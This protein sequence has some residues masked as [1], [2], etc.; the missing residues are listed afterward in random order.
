MISIDQNCHSLWD[1][2]PK[3]Q[4]LVGRGMPVRHF[5]EDIDVAFTEVGASA[6]SDNGLARPGSLRLERERYYRGREADWGA[7]LFYHQ[8]LGRQAVDIREW[9]PLTGLSTKALSGRLGRG[10]AELYEEFSPSDNWQLIGP[11]YAGQGGHHRVIGDLSVAET[12]GFLREVLRKAREDCLSAMPE[13]PCR[14]RLEEWFTREAA[15]LESLLA[16]HAAG[17]LV[18]LYKDWMASYLGA[19]V[20]LDLSSRLFGLDGDPTRFE[21]LEVF[22]RDYDVASGLYNE[23]IAETGSFLRPLEVQGGELPFFAIFPH[24]GRLVRTATFLDGESL[25]V[26]ARTFPLAPGRRLPVGA[27]AKAGIRATGGKAILLTIQARLGEV[28]APLALPYRGSVY[29]PASHRLARKLRDA[30]LL[31]GRLHPIVRVRL[32]LLDRLAD[33]NVSIRVPE[34]LAR[35]FGKDVVPAREIGLNHARLAEEAQRRLKLLETPEGRLAWQRE[36]M[37]EL[38]AQLEGLDQRRR[39]LAATNPKDPELR[40]VWK[41]LKP[42]GLDLLRRTVR[43]IEVDWQVK[44]LDYWDSR[45]A[46]LPWSIGLGGPGFYNEVIARA[47]IYEEQE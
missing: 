14:Q 18:D 42:I 46:I 22:L 38:W 2:L 21:A 24:E 16:R 6:P 1:A 32:R 43:Q 23:A 15:L 44:D 34:Y 25:R 13:E 40:A 35:C 3:L 8:F 41:R 26:G 37:P 28:G 12:Q 20:P 45:G 31:S 36:N 10:V 30:G 19:A 17:G 9:E 5:I 4:A 29:M 39:D 7:A 27:M 11:S 33:L 47:E